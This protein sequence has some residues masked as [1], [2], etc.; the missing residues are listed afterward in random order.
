MTKSI[1]KIYAAFSPVAEA[2][3]QELETVEKDVMGNGEEWLFW[4]D[5][6]LRISFEGL[7]FPIE[8][9]LAI[10][11]PH[12]TGKSSGKLDILDLEDWTLTRHELRNG[13]LTASTRSLNHVLDYAGH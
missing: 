11:E 5:G 10:L 7:Y 6:L 9:A 12:L 8:E 2:V 13:Q 4:E 1:I 3:R